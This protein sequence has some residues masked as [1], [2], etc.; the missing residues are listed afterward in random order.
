MTSEEIQQIS[1]L[2]INAGLAMSTLIVFFLARSW[3]HK[4]KK[5]F[6]TELRTEEDAHQITL[7]ISN[8]C[9]ET[10]RVT[11]IIWDAGIL[12]KDQLACQQIRNT[13]IVPNGTLQL[14]LKGAELKTLY[15]FL[16]SALKGWP[17]FFAARGIKVA[18]RISGRKDIHY[19]SITYCTAKRL[20][21]MAR[22]DQ[23]PPTSSV[24]FGSR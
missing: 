19:Q 6:V 5:I 18:V 10:I 17:I 8:S 23:D 14:V 9:P 7:K 4:S 21:K 11:N 12:L 20:L 13:K 3:V 22:D 1:G 24:S 2:L 16:L 15:Q